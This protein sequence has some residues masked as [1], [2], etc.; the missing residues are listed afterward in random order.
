MEKKPSVCKQ[1]GGSQIILLDVSAQRTQCRFIVGVKETY[2][3]DHTWFLGRITN[4]SQ[5]SMTIFN[6]FKLSKC[7]ILLCNKYEDINGCNV[8]AFVRKLQD[9]C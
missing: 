1:E 6:Q 5:L 9:V 2:F 4:R 8:Y 7:L 3:M